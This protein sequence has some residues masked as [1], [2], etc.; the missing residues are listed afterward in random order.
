MPRKG[1]AKALLR[2]ANWSYMAGRDAEGTAYVDQAA[3]VAEDDAESLCRIAS[4]YAARGR[5]REARGL[6]DRAETLRP[7]LPPIHAALAKLHENRREYR[8]AAA[9]W[10]RFAQ[11]S[12]E[13]RDPQMRLNGEQI[14]AVHARAR[15]C[16]R[17]DVEGAR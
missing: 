5:D 6:I 3:R 15:R 8:E 10:R 12:S 13:S 4:I 2:A 1:N 17:M 14:E 16:E 7:D 11:L 9:S